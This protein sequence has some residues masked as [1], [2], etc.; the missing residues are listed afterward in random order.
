MAG[1]ILAVKVS[2][3]PGQGLLFGNTVIFATSGVDCCKT[4]TGGEVSEELDKQT[5]V[6]FTVTVIAVKP[7]SELVE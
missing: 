7:R 1:A 3:A 6:E 4:N 2:G 5:S